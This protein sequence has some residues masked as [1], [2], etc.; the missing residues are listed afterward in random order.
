VGSKCKPDVRPYFE[1]QNKVAQRQILEVGDPSYFLV[2]LQS[3]VRPR[4]SC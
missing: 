3:T 2:L 1:I 4:I